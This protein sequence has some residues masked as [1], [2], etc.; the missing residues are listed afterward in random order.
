MEQFKLWS[1][2]I[3]SYTSCNQLQVNNTPTKSELRQSY[4]EVFRNEIGHCTHFKVHLQLKLQAV[5]VSRPK[6]QVAYAA[7]D[8][9]DLL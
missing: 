7:K 3:D 6:R 1:K 5:P 8:H 2:P 9:L 4:P